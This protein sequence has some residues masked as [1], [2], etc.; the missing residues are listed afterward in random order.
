M[1]FFKK[2]KA[3]AYSEPCQMYKMECFAKKINNFLSLA[4]FA[5][6]PILDVLNVLKSS[7]YAKYL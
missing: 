7:E 6:R 4:V 2:E 1:I 5:K 3:V